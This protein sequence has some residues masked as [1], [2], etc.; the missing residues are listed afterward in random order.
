MKWPPLYV[1][2]FRP[3]DFDTVGYLFYLYPIR[4]F[5]HWSRRRLEGWDF[6]GE[7]LRSWCWLNIRGSVWVVND[8]DC[9]KY[10]NN[11]RRFFLLQRIHAV[12]DRLRQPK[13]FLADS[14]RNPG[15]EDFFLFPC[16][17]GNL[18]CISE[19]ILI[20]KT[21]ICLALK[22]ILK[23]NERFELQSKMEFEWSFRFWI[24]KST[25]LSRNSWSWNSSTSVR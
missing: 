25:V 12:S 17:Q 16:V 24:I 13:F 23:M 14:K 20:K 22:L 8:L 9:W 1:P 19:L 10:S 2:W 7:R 21:M 18:K 4:R 15:F 6:K 3:L 5:G 11:E